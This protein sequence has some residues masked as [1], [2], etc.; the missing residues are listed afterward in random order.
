MEHFAA[1]APASMQNI[2]NFFRFFFLP[3]PLVA[4]EPL[5]MADMVTSMRV[6][7]RW[8]LVGDVKI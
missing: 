2:F 8:G 3:P 7:S 1:Y 5:K 6:G 4:T